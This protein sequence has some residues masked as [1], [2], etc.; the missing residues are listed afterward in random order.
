MSSLL[1]FGR[2]AC[3]RVVVGTLSKKE[4]AQAVQDEKNRQSARSFDSQKY[5]E[6]ADWK[7]KAAA[8]GTGLG[9]CGASGTSESWISFVL[10]LIIVV[11]VFL[12]IR[13]VQRA[14]RRSPIKDRWTHLCRHAR[15][16]GV[17]TDTG[18]AVRQ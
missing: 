16:R 15:S 12:T 7:R 8:G 18:M 6:W 5:N 14:L 9:S 4:L 3:S 2:K 10:C 13:V 1:L 11:A 17:E